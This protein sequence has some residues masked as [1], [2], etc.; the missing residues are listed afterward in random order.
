MAQLKEEAN[1]VRRPVKRKR[2][3]H[4][5]AGESNDGVRELSHSKLGQEE[6]DNDEMLIGS[7]VKIIDDK[8]MRGNK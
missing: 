3:S 7:D 1:F 8:R 2:V 6:F 5:S 4:K